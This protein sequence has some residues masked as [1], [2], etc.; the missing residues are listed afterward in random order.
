M[1]KV[2]SLTGEKIV[3]LA[4][5]FWRRWRA[6]LVDRQAQR[7]H[8]L[9]ASKYDT[10]KVVAAFS[11]T[12]LQEVDLDQLRTQ[13]LAVVQETMQPTHVSLWLREGSRTETRSLQAGKPPEETG[14]HEE[15][16]EHG[17]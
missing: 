17:A 4:V 10:A 14:V 6:I 12:L 15:V 13:L 9:R 2:E 16:A 5:T 7:R 8:R 1:A 11:S 3:T